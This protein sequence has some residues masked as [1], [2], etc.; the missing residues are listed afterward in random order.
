MPAAPEKYPAAENWDN[1]KLSSA[2]HQRKQDLQSMEFIMT[3]YR[4]N[5]NVYWHANHSPDCT[6]RLLY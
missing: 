4:L 3:A 1:V 6:C 5:Y 2:D